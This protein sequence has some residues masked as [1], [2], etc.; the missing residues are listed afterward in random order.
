MENNKQIKFQK[1]KSEN[2][3][4]K[5]DTQELFNQPYINDLTQLLKTHQTIPTHTPKKLIDCFYLYWDGSTTYELYLYINN[6]WK[7]VILS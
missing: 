7:K 2:K 1:I 6:T 5:F 4:I 3:D